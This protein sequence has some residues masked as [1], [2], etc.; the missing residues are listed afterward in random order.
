MEIT[1]LGRSGFRLRSKDVA[2]VIDPPS[3]A[4]GAALKG[5][6][7]DIVCVTHQHAGHNNVQGVGGDPHIVD[8]PGEYEIK[9][10]LITAMRA[11]HDAKHGE[12]RGTNTIYIIHMEDLLICHLGDI[13]HSLNAAQTQEIAGADV[14]MIP[15]GGKTT[16]NARTAAAIVGEIEPSII[17]PMHFGPGPNGGISTGG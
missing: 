17:L 2:L 16:I 4:Y 13:G 7:A 15:V 10:V 1:A 9:G 11:F 8:G 14:L 6:S 5:V 3:P 12:E